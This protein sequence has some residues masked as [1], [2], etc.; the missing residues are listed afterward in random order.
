MKW[1]RKNDV[2]RCGVVAAVDSSLAVEIY[3][4]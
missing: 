2:R 1:P 4:A 3:A